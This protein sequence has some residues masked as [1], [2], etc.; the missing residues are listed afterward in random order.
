MVARARP[1]EPKPRPLLPPAPRPRPP[2]RPP[3]RPPRALP[4]APMSLLMRRG[5]EQRVWYSHHWPQDLLERRAR[6]DAT[7]SEGLPGVERRAAEAPPV[8]VM[9]RSAGVTGW[10]GGGGFGG[11]ALRVRIVA[12]AQGPLVGG[13]AGR[14]VHGLV[15][16]GGIDRRLAAAAAAS[17][18]AVGAGRGEDGVERLDGAAARVAACVA[19]R[20]GHDQTVVV[21]RAAHGNVVVVGAVCV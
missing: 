2:L 18:I 19:A 21:V 12:S 3:P 10:V 6:P 16:W 17:A 8:R 13:V 9:E 20:E 11:V 7:K 5:S 14:V 15:V 1:P 4:P